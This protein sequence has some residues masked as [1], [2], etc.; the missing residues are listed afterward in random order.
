MKKQLLFLSGAISCFTIAAC[1]IASVKY[2]QPINPP[3]TTSVNPATGNNNNQQQPPNGSRDNT[4]SDSKN[5]NDKE[6]TT[7]IPIVNKCDLIARPGKLTLGGMMSDTVA[8]EKYVYQLTPGLNCEGH[9]VSLV[10]AEHVTRKEM[11]IKKDYEVNLNSLDSFSIGNLGCSQSQVE[12]LINLNNKTVHVLQL[13]QNLN[14]VEKFDVVAICGNHDLSSKSLDI[15]ASKILFIDANF[16]S[17]SDTS[18][19]LSFNAREIQFHGC[20]DIIAIGNT[21]LTL[22]A[23]NKQCNYGHLNVNLVGAGGAAA[24]S[25]CKE[26]TAYSNK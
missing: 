25:Q 9:K 4:R 10:E 7:A 3:A 15:S 12:S 20:N 19:L 5:T 11:S 16:H 1:D 17:K 18:T 26:K 8:S 21:D 24:S 23:K 2:K 13:N 14:I 22:N 6:K